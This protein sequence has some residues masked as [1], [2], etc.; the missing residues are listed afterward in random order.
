MD[1]WGSTAPCSMLDVIEISKFQVAST[2][3][4]GD[5]FQAFVSVSLGNK[6]LKT[7]TV[8]MGIVYI[9]IESIEIP[10]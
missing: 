1:G 10:V 2:I 5:I 9:D 8:C 6:D 7:S 4:N 3:T